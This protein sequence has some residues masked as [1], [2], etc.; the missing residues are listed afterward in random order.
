MRLLKLWNKTEDNMCKAWGG[1]CC[2]VR[3]S[4]FSRLRCWEQLA[5]A[6]NCLV[7]ELMSVVAKLRTRDGRRNSPTFPT[8]TQP[9]ALDTNLGHCLAAS[10]IVLHL[11]GLCCSGGWGRQ[12]TAVVWTTV[13]EAWRLGGRMWLTESSP[14]TVTYWVILTNYL[15]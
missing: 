4:D 9:Q 3:S 11:S 2:P 5:A 15:T 1:H 10:C 7:I 8:T 14:G 13:W 6:H 12:G